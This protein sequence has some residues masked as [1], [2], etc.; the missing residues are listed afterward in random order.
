MTGHSEAL[1]YEQAAATRDKLRAV[2]RTMEQQKMAA[3]SRA[4]HDAIGMARAEDEACLQVMQVRNGKLIGREHY[5]VV[6]ARDVPDAEVLG[7]FLQQYYATTDAVP[8]ALLVPVLPDAAPTTSPRTSPIVA[9][10]ASRSPCQ[11]AARSGASWRSRRRTRW[12]RSSVS[13][14]NGW[15]MPPGATRRSTSWRRALDLPRRRSRIEC[16]DMS[17]IQGTSAVG[18]MVVFIDGRPEPR[19][20]RRFRIRSGETPDDFRMMAEVLR[21]RFSRVAKLRAE[22]GALSSARSAPTRSGQRAEPGLEAKPARSTTAG[23]RRWAVRTS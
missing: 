11:S 6:G 1:R 9:A 18:S 3:F 23:S 12:R 19:E 2:E 7:S 10:Y 13:E 15:P 4:E 16:Y 20:Y 5:I 14:P 8:R 22:T 21:R 17:N